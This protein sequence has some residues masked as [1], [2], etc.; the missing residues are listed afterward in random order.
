MA[1]QLIDG[2]IRDIDSAKTVQ[3]KQKIV[4]CGGGNAAHVFCTLASSNPN[5]EVHLLSLYKTEAKDFQAALSQTEDKMITIDVTQ[6]K[7]QIKAKPSNITNDPKCLA[8]ADIVILS[9]PAFA[10]NQYLNVIK[11]HTKPR[12]NRKTLVAV[13][14]GASGLECEWQS[15]FGADSKGFILLSCI[16]L[17]WACRILQFGQNAEILGTKHQVEVCLKSVDE[18]KMSDYKAKTQTN[19]AWIEQISRIIG[20]PPVIVDNGHI[21]NMSLS[22]V[23]AIVHPSIMFA[24]WRD[25]DGTPLDVKPLFYQGIDEDAAK[26]VSDLSDEALNIT[27]CVEEET[28]LTLVTQ[29]I[30]DWFKKCYGAECKDTSSLY[31]II[32]TNPGYDG[33]TH[34]MKEIDGKYVPNWNYRYLSEDIPYGLVVIRGLSLILDGKHKCNAPQ[35][36]NI[37]KWSQGLLGAEYLKYNEDGTIVAGKDINRSR[38]PQRYGIK[39]IKDLV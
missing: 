16:T 37:I 6:E 29:H 38:A 7:R 35:M 28:G 34:P 36:D 24:R 20:R 26:L 15:I 2:I 23:N 13:F 33:L 25:Y 11:E 19:K 10:H 12:D 21:L 5:N 1:L 14:P 4:V 18:Q 17:P 27:K 9:L 31:K 3:T 22:A 30:Y 39:S 32:L 8:N